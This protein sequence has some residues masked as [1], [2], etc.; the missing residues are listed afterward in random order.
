MPLSGTGAPLGV[1]IYSLLLYSSPTRTPAAPRAAHL[2]PDP[3]G[4]CLLKPWG[5]QMVGFLVQVVV[6]SVL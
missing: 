4:A 3:S 6:P 5:P 2:S 1:C